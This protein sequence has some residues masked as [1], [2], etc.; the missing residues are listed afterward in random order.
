MH[1][2]LQLLCCNP[3][4][5]WEEHLRVDPSK[6]PWIMV[7]ISI[8]SGAKGVDSRQTAVCGSE[9]LAVT[10]LVKLTQY[11]VEEYWQWNIKFSSKIWTAITFQIAQGKN[12]ISGRSGIRIWSFPFSRYPC[13]L[14]SKQINRCTFRSVNYIPQKN[15]MCPVDCWNFILPSLFWIVAWNELYSYSS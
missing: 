7:S 4:K 10:S 5:M 8:G 11:A 3:T 9:L 14:G 6:S 2:W 15:V 1:W 13:C 12:S